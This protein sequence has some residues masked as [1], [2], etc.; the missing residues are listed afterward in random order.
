MKPISLKSSVR[1][2]PACEYLQLTSA[3]P[4]LSHLPLLP[5]HTRR[6]NSY[7][8]YFH[9]PADWSLL[10]CDAIVFIVIF[11]EGLPSRPLYILERGNFSF[12]DQ[13][14]SYTIA[15]PSSFILSICFLLC[16]SS[17]C[18]ARSFWLAFWIKISLEQ[19]I[20][21]SFCYYYDAH[22]T[23]DQIRLFVCFSL[24]PSSPLI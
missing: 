3:I 11:L 19:Y 6:E 9:S 2:V 14:Y 12:F 15:G 5:T 21:N 13:I 23:V 24:F 22:L 4:A 7:P 17:L 20:A 18:R 10:L 8:D 16:C 1:V